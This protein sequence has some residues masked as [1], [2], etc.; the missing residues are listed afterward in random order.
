MKGS[1]ISKCYS[2]KYLHRIF[3]VM[4][5]E[6]AKVAEQPKSSLSNSDK[7]LA[8]SNGTKV[9]LQEK[10]CQLEPFLPH[11]LISSQI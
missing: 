4:N 5:T 6:K 9:E 8:S 3:N 1:F 7:D 2:V 11:I 10:Y